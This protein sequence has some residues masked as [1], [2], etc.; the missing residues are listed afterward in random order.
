MGIARRFFRD[1]EITSSITDINECLIRRFSII[2]QTLACG[3]HA[4]KFDKY[5]SETA[6]LMLN[7][8]VGI[9]CQHQFIRF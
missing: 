5:A 9:T 6:K 7:Y 8:I 2:L 3:K 1:P 4:N